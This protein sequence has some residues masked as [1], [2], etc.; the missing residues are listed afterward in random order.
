MF[1]LREFS[2]R[3]RN[4]TEGY[5]A[6]SQAMHWI[7]VALV[8]LAWVLG[9]FDDIFPKG[10]LRAGSLFVH[11]SA[12][13]AVVGVLVLRLIWRVA[14]PP[15]PIEHRSLGAWL[16]R[17]GKLSHNVLYALLLAVPVSGI[18]LQFARGDALPLFGW[19]SI[20]SPWIAD[21][22]FARTAKEVHELAANAL[23][24]LAAFHAAA[25]LGHHWVLRDRALARMLPRA[26]RDSRP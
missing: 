4:S 19:D 15:P 8:I 20:A 1:D 26:W 5:G 17:A 14:D 6:I 9:Q 11:I 25:A 16:D 21:R 3:W 23:I 13:L 2:M 7:T 22:A 12:G 18:V 10:P 24:I